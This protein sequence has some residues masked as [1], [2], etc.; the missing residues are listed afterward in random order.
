[1]KQAQLHI[2]S[3]LGQPTRVECNWSA[4]INDSKSYT[5]RGVDSGGVI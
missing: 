3:L 5:F 1:M 2:A 4:L